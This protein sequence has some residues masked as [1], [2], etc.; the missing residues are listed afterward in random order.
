ML[1][2]FGQIFSFFSSSAGEEEDVHVSKDLALGPQNSLDE[3]DISPLIDDAKKKLHTY[4][5]SDEELLYALVSRGGIKYRNETLNIVQGESLDALRARVQLNGRQLLDKVGGE[6]SEY[7]IVDYVRR[8]GML[9]NDDDNSLK[10]DSFLEGKLSRADV[11]YYE[12]LVFRIVA[13]VI[14]SSLNYSSDAATLISNQNKMK[15][16]IYAAL[17][18]IIIED[19]KAKAE[20][21]A[22]AKAKAE[23]KLHLFL[24]LSA[25]IV[26]V[27]L[28]AVSLIYFL[29]LFI[30]GLLVVGLGIAGACYICH[31][32]VD[33]NEADDLVGGINFDPERISP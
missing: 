23:F 5:Q 19:I 9:F 24:S 14:T 25:I 30:L 29:P 22:E 16:Q 4:L 11:I 2:T 18:E 28:L 21:E 1:A 27:I 12:A 13:D 17:S 6:Q 33:I 7:K 32:A 3:V 31:S 15:K 20:A 10:L 8:F 26:G